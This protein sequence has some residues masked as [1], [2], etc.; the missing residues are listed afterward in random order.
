[1]RK[2]TIIGL[3]L[4]AFCIAC[5]YLRPVADF[6]AE[7]LY[8][9]ISGGLSAIA[10][11]VPFSLEEI[12][13]L[14]FA[15]AVIT[16]I[17]R[18]VRRREKFAR[19]SGRL[20]STLIWVLV[21]F[22]MGW[23]NNYYRTG[24]YERGG[25]QRLAYDEAD[26]KAFLQS[27]T[28]GLNKSAAEAGSCDKDLLE[29]EI[30]EFY[31]IEASRYG[32]TKLRSWQH[33]KRPVFNR[34]FSAVTVQGYMG[35]FFCESQVNSDVSEAEYAFVAAHEMAHLAGVTS[36]AEA[37]YW[38]FACC[39]ISQSGATRYSGYLGLLP[40]V[41][42]NA[43]GLLPE[44]DFDAWTASICDK[45]KSDYTE[46]RQNWKEKRVDWIEKAQ[47]SLQDLMLKGNG[48][49]AGTKDYFSVVAMVMTMDAARGRQ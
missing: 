30:K 49:R 20:I 5:R 16:I 22:Y 31:A 24:L 26:F 15:V 8:P 1:M 28:A 43:K 34:L 36:E 25:I 38:G 11:T 10:S 41:L 46:A 17:V 2:R 4:L 18:A 7:K 14:C 23:G 21:W 47:R 39:R 37:N 45:A 19:W 48:V 40:H 44:E 33:I 13:V 9:V 6:Y 29:D 27:Y 12:V 35:P 32:Y 42:M 3:C